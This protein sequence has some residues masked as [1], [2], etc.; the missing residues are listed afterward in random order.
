M[1]VYREFSQWKM[2]II[3]SYISLPEGKVLVKYLYIAEKR[4]WL[5]I[6]IKY[7]KSQHAGKP[8]LHPKLVIESNKLSGSLAVLGAASNLVSG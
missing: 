4:Q 1:V 6:F 2:G 7:S 3:H 8:S 5:H